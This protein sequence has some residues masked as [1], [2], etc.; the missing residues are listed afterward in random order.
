MTKWSSVRRL[1]RWR[2][3]AKFTRSRPTPAAT[4]SS[5]ESMIPLSSAR[6]I[7]ISLNARTPDVYRREYGVCRMIDLVSSMSPLRTSAGGFRMWSL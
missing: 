2:T 1:S 5:N 7:S 4:I 3:Q 6:G